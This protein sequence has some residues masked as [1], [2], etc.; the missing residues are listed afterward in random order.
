MARKKTLEQEINEFIEVW[1]ADQMNAFFRDIYPL[2][3]LYNVNE[4]DDW[5]T[6]AVGKENTQTIRII[7]TVY[8]ISRIAEF[9]AGKLANVRINF[10]DLYRRMEKSGTIEVTKSES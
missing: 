10:A 5:V 6:D 4:D 2:I 9:H 1:N 7:R 3:E 8:L